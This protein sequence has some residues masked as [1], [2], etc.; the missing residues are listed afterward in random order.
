MK[1]LTHKAR[2][3]RYTAVLVPDDVSDTQTEAA[4]GVVLGPPDL[5]SLNL[6]TALEVR[7]HNELY[8]RGLL[9]RKDLITK[10]PEVFA[11][12]QA[13]LRVDAAAI[14]NLYNEG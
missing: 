2:D 1:I 5:G 13:A 4:K 7:L 8:H 3:G 14:L 10:Q 6:P 9:T 12:L 11:A